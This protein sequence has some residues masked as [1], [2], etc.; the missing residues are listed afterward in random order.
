MATDRR[1]S[2]KK[3]VGQNLNDLDRRVKKV[4]RRNRSTIDRWSVTGDNLAPGS[5]T[6]DK[7]DPAL[8]ALIRTIYSANDAAGDS[9]EEGNYS[10]YEEVESVYSFSTNSAS[11]KNS[12]FYSPTE[13]AGDAFSID[14]IWFDTAPD[15]DG[16]PK[17]EPHK[18]D[19]DSWEPA[20]LGDAA[21]RFLDV[22]K[23]AT[24]VLDA[25]VQIRVGQFPTQPGLRR[26]EITGGSGVAFYETTLS[27]NI[28]STAL[29]MTVT[30]ASVFSAV[31]PPYHLVL[32]GDDNTKIEIVRVTE[33]SGNTLTIVRGR[34]PR[35]HISGAKAQYKETTTAGFRVLQNDYSQSFWDG[36]TPAVQ[37]ALQGN[38]TELFSL[39]AND[40][41][42]FL[43]SG[44]ETLKFNTVDS[45]NRLSISGQIRVGEGLESLLIGKDLV[46]GANNL[47][48]DGIQL[49]TQ[50]FWYRPNNAVAS[51]STYF[52]VSGGGTKAIRVEKDG[53]VFVEGTTNPTGGTIKGRLSVRLGEGNASDKFIIGQNVSTLSGLT[54]DEFDGIKLNTNNY[55]V[56]S[57]TGKRAYLRVGGSNNYV[58]YNPVTDKL[59]LSGQLVAGEGTAN[60]VSVGA[61]VGGAGI[62]GVKIDNSNYWYDADKVSASATVFK[63]S[64]A[65][66]TAIT[67]NKAGD[68]TVEGITNPT[69][70]TVKGRLS[71]RLAA[72]N[73]AEKFL[74]GQN[75][76]SLAGVSGDEFD[77]IKL[78]THNYWVLS[79]TGK[80]SYLK[81][82][83]AT[84]NLFFDGSTGLLKLTGG[85]I[86]LTG[87]GTFK[88]ADADTRVEMTSDGIFG[89]KAGTANP[90]FYIRAS[91]GTAS[92]EGET[93]PTSGTVKGKLTIQ[94][95]TYAFGKDVMS[96]RDGL[97]L[98]ANNHWVLSQTGGSSTFRVG[99]SSKYLEYNSA[100]ETFTI[101][102]DTISLGGVSIQNSLNGKANNSGSTILSLLNTGMGTGVVLTSD[103]KIYSA[104]KTSYNSSTAG[105]YLGRD[106]TVVGGVSALRYT[107][108]IGN[109]T[110]YLRW[111]GDS[112]NV[113]GSIEATSGEIGGWDI[114]STT[115]YSQSSSAGLPYVR[116]TSG[117][118]PKIEFGD[119]DSITTFKQNSI[120]MK[121]YWSPSADS[122]PFQVRQSVFGTATTTDLALYSI[123]NT[124]TRI[125][126]IRLIDTVNAPN[127]PTLTDASSA[128][129]MQVDGN[130]TINGN[131]TVT[132]TGGGSSGGYRNATD[133]TT[134]NKITYG[135]SPPGTGTGR[136]AGDIHIEF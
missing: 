84:K 49:G 65:N 57:N 63:V 14:D 95:T 53:D 4:E 12:I 82:G 131:L 110:N 20:P 27:A 111:D 134:T 91:D 32:D 48:K 29:S 8:V 44:D 97:Y 36:K 124:T 118:D 58:S 115:I 107:F 86:T 89:Y 3:S 28:T 98:N 80:K 25:A 69:G 105:W 101:N 104:G 132:G 40:G 85:D 103:G 54:G 83:T 59:K 108:G 123:V 78:D 51:N 87:G 112:V 21:F 136:S 113:K 37:S 9:L 125:G 77:G 135:G 30:D 119:E 45:P 31:P 43:G 116:L 128:F 13:P 16:D 126:G 129:S 93:N 127:Y 60:T 52:Q 67:V 11:G 5:I 34:T 75:L 79:N 70:G 94:G 122:G 15:T 24:G 96:T 18:W 66:S 114:D 61:D 90:I 88:T 106:I 46:D 26:L 81:V 102:A 6:I 7:L 100:S 38:L 41:S 74:I 1:R 130:V 76:P 35:A 92:F 55:W 2:A 72:D 133:G 56:L 17:Y 121:T 10:L 71:I 39:N 68:V 99:G 109:A 42:L 23:L 73:A 47:K 62:A 117:T 50:N 19:G 120:N 33:V 64:G 22:G